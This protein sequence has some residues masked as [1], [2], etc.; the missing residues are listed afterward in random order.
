MVA[1]GDLGVEIPFREIPALQ[2]LMIEKCIYSG[3]IVVTA[4]QMLESMTHSPRP[5]RAE[6]SDVANAVY[7][8][9]TEY[10]PGNSDTR[11][12]YARGRFCRMHRLQM[13]VWQWQN[14]WRRSRMFMNPAR[15]QG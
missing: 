2:K 15:M 1:R 3:K 13:K 10:L 9:T 5:T 6:V 7:D 14:A 4:T 11:M 8:G 12:Q